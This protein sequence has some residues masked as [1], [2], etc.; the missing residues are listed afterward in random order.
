MGKAKLASLLAIFTLLLPGT[1][2][3]SQPSMSIDSAT[4]RIMMRASRK[5]IREV[6]K[7][8]SEFPLKVRQ[9]QIKARLLELT[10]DAVQTFGI[11]LERLTGVKVPLETVREGTSIKLGGGELQYI[12]YR[13]MPGEERLEAII[14]ALISTG[15][16]EVLSEPEVSTLSGQVAGVYVVED[17]A[18]KKGEKKDPETGEITEEVEY[19]T[20][21]IVLQVL[22]DIVGK[23]LVQMSVVPLVSRARPHPTFGWERPIFSRE[24]SPTNITIGSGETIVI[25]GLTREEKTNTIAGL[26]ILSDL[27][28]IGDLFKARV[29]MTS[30]RHLLVTVEPHVITPREVKGREK[31]VFVFKYALAQEMAK[32]VR[33]ILSSE[34]IME[35]NPKEAPPNS[36]LVRD[37][38]DKIEVIQALLDEIGTFEQQRREETFE[39][40]YSTPDQINKAILPLLS[41][42]GSS[43]IDEEAKT[44]TIEDGAYQLARMREIISS[45]ERHNQV[46]QTKVFY[47]D[48]LD[49]DEILPLLEKYLSPQGSIQLEEDKLVVVDNNWVIQRIAEGITRWQEKLK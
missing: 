41:P 40:S 21:G 2:G 49:K 5:E 48:E 27:P 30:K 18:Y 8:I 38:E 45:M 32:R 22:P 12:F 42:R 25:G 7:T 14:N 29:E 20:V 35:M 4:G 11:S 13:L 26:P 23:D 34:G 1:E 17:V 19:V 31:K 47:L 37:N 33:E 24:I 28:I 46:P 36:I 10:E 16:A 39:L 6:G 44:L 3:G 9:I 43:G 15:K